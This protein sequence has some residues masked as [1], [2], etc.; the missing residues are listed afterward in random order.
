MLTLAQ[1]IKIYPGDYTEIEQLS[2]G[3]I[4]KTYRVKCTDGKSLIFQQFNLSVFKR[5][6]LVE[7]NY[8]RSL[9][10]LE[11]NNIFL[12][13]FYINKQ[14]GIFFEGDWRIC[15][16]L[17]NSTTSE[18]CKSEK[19]AFEAGRISGSF[20]K[21][22]SKESGYPFIIDNFHSPSFRF[23]ALPKYTEET[24][25]LFS[26]I[27]TLKSE[28]LRLEKKPFSITH[29]DLK[30]TNILFVGDE[31]KA[32]IDLDLIQ[33]GSPEIDFGDLLRSVGT[34]G[35]EDQFS[36]ADM[37]LVS[38]CISGFISSG[39]SF[40]PEF[41]ALSPFVVSWT[42][43]V[44]FLTDYLS[45]DIYFTTHYPKQNLKRAEAQIARAKMW[46]EK[47]ESLLREIKNA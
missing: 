14:G 43:G 15:E 2:G 35:V 24:K 7:N 21:A 10:V 20:L 42:L 37:S 36:E 17:E 29:N 31:A 19:M 38:S 41:L 44:R 18:I 39:V 22:L 8:L 6:D 9:K 25:K 13:P 34:K 40:D 11:R 28:A 47:S 26:E 23:K 16:Y 5:K 33:P 45:G 27:D 12:L 32:V 3:H 1:A 46:L 4:H 30:L